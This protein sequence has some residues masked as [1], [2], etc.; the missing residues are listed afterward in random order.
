MAKQQGNKGESGV[1]SNPCWQ[2]RIHDEA[3]QGEFP[4]EKLHLIE[5]EEDRHRLRMKMTPPE[6]EVHPPEGD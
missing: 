5:D 4:I 1:G 2:M 3:R 6:D